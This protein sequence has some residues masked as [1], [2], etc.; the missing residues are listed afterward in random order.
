ML[1]M[2]TAMVSGG[3]GQV[4]DIP[5]GTQ[6]IHIKYEKPDGIESVKR[7][8]LL[9]PVAGFEYVLAGFMGQYQNIEDYPGVWQGA[10]LVNL[11]DQIK[12]REIINSR[13]YG[14]T[15]RLVMD[16]KRSSL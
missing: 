9:R 5:E 3:R 11:D 10:V 6:E 12:S 1:V 13:T 16:E 15:Y 7:F 2:V 8:A 14:T 4:F